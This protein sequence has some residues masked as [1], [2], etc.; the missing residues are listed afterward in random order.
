M[1]RRDEF[2]GE[3]YR[4]TQAGP[5]VGLKPA[6]RGTRSHYAPG[7]CCR[8]TSPKRTA[9]DT[10]MSACFSHS[11]SHPQ[12]TTMLSRKCMAGGLPRTSCPGA[13]MP[14]LTISVRIRDLLQVNVVCSNGHIT[15]IGIIQH[16]DFY[17]PGQRREHLN[18]TD[19]LIPL[20][21]SGVGLHRC[22]PLRRRRCESHI[23]STSA[24]KKGCL[25]GCLGM[26]C[27]LIPPADGAG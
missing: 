3:P 22:F 10:R 13:A 20:R 7:C 16:L 21:L 24:Q 9:Q 2:W 25:R 4:F 19:L 18:E 6:K 8:E 15:D 27:T 17:L 12:E 5:N 14:S 26:P 1:S 11:C 23:V